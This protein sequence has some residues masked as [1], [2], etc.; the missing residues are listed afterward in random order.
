MLRTWEFQ[1]SPR[2][3]FGRGL[4]RKLGEVA[5]PLGQSAL[6]VG[7]ANPDHLE[8]TYGRATIAL[9]DAGLTVTRFFQVPC[10]PDADLVIEG[11][12]QAHDA[13]ADVVIGLGGGSV[14]DAAK[15][16]A[17][18]AR[19]GGKHWDYNSANI[20]C[21]PVT[22]AL[23]VVAVPTT[24]GTGTE[25]SAAAGAHLSRRGG[26]ATP[27]PENGPLWPR[28]LP[29]RGSGRPRVERRFAASANS[30]QRGR[31]LGTCHRGLHE[32]PGEPPLV[33]VRRPGGGPDRGQP[34]SRGG[35]PHG[36]RAPRSLGPGRH[37]GRRRVQRS[38][39][40][41]HPRDRPRLGCLVE[42]SAQPGVAAATPV[43]LRSMPSAAWS[44]M[45]PWPRPAA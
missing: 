44:P 27:P 10:D 19:M 23:P 24:A 42:H 5:R 8:E 4:L 29:P 14:I 21:R 28:D 2:V 16:I 1:L 37:L 26:F 9:R 39:R 34:P 18:V 35:E 3:L 7:Y 31:C 38:G 13:R 11:M 32:P 36:A 45:P 15:G 40:R 22:D 43:N 30:R 33:V 25:V 41:G 6:L 12:Q 20:Q 17:D